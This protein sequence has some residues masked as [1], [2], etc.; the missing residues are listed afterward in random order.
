MTQRAGPASSTADY[1]TKGTDKASLAGGKPQDP[2]QIIAEARGR[3]LGLL[4]GRGIEIGALH[5]PC[6]APHL[7]V[8]YVDRLTRAELLEQY[9]ELKGQPIVE[10][11]VI[12]D[13]ETLRTLPD[14]SQ[15]FVIANHV[16]EHMANPIKTL[17]AWSRVLKVGGRLF[18][19]VPDK[20]HTFDK[21]RP[22]T[23]IAHLVQDFEQPSQERDYEHFREFA[24]YV[25]CR[26]FHV[27]PESEAEQVAQE[28]WAKQYSIHYH[29]WDH[30]AFGAFI[31]HV[32]RAF[33][34]GGMTI[35][36]RTPTRG[37][38]FLYL[39]ERRAV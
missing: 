29:V 5:R 11:G 16:I 17:L 25:T 2:Q 10:T 18:M 36:E 7:N 27:R 39:L 23:P 26:T 3:L 8:T 28:L 32:L 37:D 4:S 20:H 12:D 30:D 33:P 14:G 21:D 1:G 13:A 35:L 9:P 6:Y 24:L 34:D 38:E 19:A 22:L 15:D 31:D